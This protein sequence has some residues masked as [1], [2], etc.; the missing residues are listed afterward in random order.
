MLLPDLLGIATPCPTPHAGTCYLCGSETDAG[1]DE[2]PSSSF[3][4]W[5]S[6][7]AGDVMC[8]GCYALVKDKSW[9]HSSWWAWCEGDKTQTLAL[10]KDTGAQ[11]F[12]LLADPPPPPFACYITQGRRK[13]GELNIIRYVSE[14]RTAYWVGTD[15][16]TRPVYMQTDFAREW[17]SLVVRMRERKVSRVALAGGEYTMKHY[18]T[19]I[20]QG[21][22]ADLEAARK[23]ARDARWEVLVHAFVG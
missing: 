9:H 18:E 19:A 14:S 23:L 11:W 8:P 1:W 3:T 10:W 15:W 20:K 17:C 4:A 13:H 6:C 5:A 16:L 12:A 21:W 22:E 7:Y 2:Q